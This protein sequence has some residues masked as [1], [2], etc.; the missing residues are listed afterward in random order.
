MN[1]EKYFIFRNTRY[2]T[3]I[4]DYDFSSTRKTSTDKGLWYEPKKGNPFISPRN[5]ELKTIF[6]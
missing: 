6:R 1:D 3:D 5:T 2:K 4:K